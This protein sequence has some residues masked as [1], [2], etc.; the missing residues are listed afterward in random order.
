MGF[1]KR[2]SG[3]VLA[4]MV[5]CPVYAAN[6]VNLGEVTQ[7]YRILP[8]DVLEISVWRE[9]G[10]KEKVL[11][12]P[13]GGASFPLIGEFRAGG[14][15]VEQLRSGVAAMLG[16]FLSEPGVTVAVV[17]T[18]QKVYVLGKV[19]RPGDVPM[20]KGVTVMQALAMAGGLTPYADRDDIA[21]LRP[22][23]GETLRFLFDYDG[24]S[25]GETLEQNILLRDGDVVVVP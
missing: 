3:V 2:L 9:E 18:N 17:S 22:Q 6:D 5:A 4:G 16:E 8:G 24:V 23:G 14:L 25:Q 21:V 19:A 13:D 11:V 7:D 1:L 12:R 10:L 20:P 15:T